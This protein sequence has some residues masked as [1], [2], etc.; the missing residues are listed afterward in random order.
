MSPYF[1]S[2]LLFTGLA[3]SSIIKKARNESTVSCR[4][5]PGDDGWPAPALWN[6]LNKTVDG[7]LIATNPIAHVCHGDSYS[8]AECSELADQWDVPALMT[9][10][11]AEILAPWFQNQTCVPFTPVS[12]PCELGNYASYSI[13]V[14]STDDIAAG[15]AFAQENNIR[16]VIKNSGH[17][18]YG[19]STGK[20]ALSLWTHN[21]NSQEI[22]PNYNS[23]FY[24]GPALKAGAG[25]QGAAA[26]EFAAQ[27]G[28]RVVVGSCPDVG[29]VGGF[30]QG[31]GL[32]LLSGMYG[33]GADNVLEWELITA[34]GEHLVATPTQNTD[35]YW[36]LSGGGGGTYGVVVSLTTRL[37]EDRQAASASISFTVETAGGVDE[38]WDAVG[39]FYSE[40]E[41]LVND[42]GISVDM[43]VSNETLYVVS[44]MAAGHSV[45]ELQTLLTPMISALSN[46]G[47]GSLTEQSLGV[48]VTGGDTYYD[49]YA[50]AVEPIIAPNPLPPVLGGRFV[51]RDN[52]A[53]NA[54]N[55]LNTMR[56]ATEGGRFSLAVTA[57]ST[58]SSSRIAEPISSNSVEPYFSDAFLSI[59]V[60]AE[61]EWEQDWNDAIQLQEELN[62]RIAPMLEAATPGAG[63]Y[64][65]EGNWQ[66]ANWQQEFYGDNYDRLRKIK[67]ANDPNGIF[68]GITN[69]GS[70]AWAPDA[71]GRLC[72][73]GL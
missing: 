57:F 38:F 31:G 33:L 41:L 42:H 68:Y 10:L 7:R 15:L 39:V 27:N 1:I 22:I 63:V 18:Y 53:S 30:T 36:A 4:Y 2:V 26:A 59:I 69:V 5:I 12:T 49:L 64:M 34:S 46:T 28:Y 47:S 43:L 23:S 6:Q 19:K 73:T 51:T 62:D 61:W 60:V 25:V 35:L 65:N 11:P 52:M 50:A 29:F 20:G 3:T 37:F 48:N 56:S 72:K 17:D 16:L 9:S 55:I 54:S 8:E 58:N 13:N 32:S 40:L 70:E 44:L 66:Q 14:S 45:D 24:N 67:S 71:D 21:V